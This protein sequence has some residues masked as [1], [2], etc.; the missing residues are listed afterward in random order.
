MIQN[1]TLHNWQIKQSIAK[2][3]EINNP[4]SPKNLS[5]YCCWLFVALQDSKQN[6]YFEITNTNPKKTSKLD[7]ISNKQSF[8]LSHQNYFDSISTL[9]KGI[10]SKI[11]IC[12][13]ATRLIMETL[14][15][16]RHNNKK[17][18]ISVIN[19][20]LWSFSSRPIISRWRSNFFTC[21][22]FIRCVPKDTFLSQNCRKQQV[23]AELDKSFCPTKNVSSLCSCSR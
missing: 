22:R 11:Q 8:S 2:T 10:W 9:D 6:F 19:M 1:K 5:N 20:L 17:H 4:N 13:Q 18:H 12:M 23:Q 7:I 16:W 14:L 3:F 21:M 15:K